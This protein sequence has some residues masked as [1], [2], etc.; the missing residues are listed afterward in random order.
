MNIQLSG[1]IS[2]QRQHQTINTFIKMEQSRLLEMDESDFQR[3]IAEVEIS[4][5]FKRLCYEEKII[6]FH[7]FPKTDISPS[8][9]QLKDN[10]VADEGSLDIKSLV[11]DNEMVV[12]LVQKL[13]IER[14]K[15]YFLFNQTDFSEQDIALECQLDLTQVRAINHLLDEFSTRSEFYHPSAFGNETTRY[16]RIASIERNKE[17]F[18]IGY[19]SPSYAKGKYQIDHERLAVLISKGIISEKD[20][21]EAKQLVK[22]L[23]L[24]NSRKDTVTNILLGIMEKQNLYFQSGDIKSLLT[25]SQKELAA[26]IGVVPSSV[27]RAIYAK[28]IDLPWGEEKPL[29]E[30]FPRP[31]MFKKLIL[32][33]ILDQE[34][35]PRSDEQIRKQL[36]KDYGISVSRRSVARFRKDLNIQASRIRGKKTILTLTE[37]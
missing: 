5:L 27:S 1:Q 28:S 2:T 16:K 19:Y 23:E 6:T 31:S 34:E 37:D 4:P 32:K 9:Y 33:Q 26:N 8:F 12:S 14:F 21:L 35:E 30:F 20:A 25:F 24:I 36:E 29:K 18:I 17:G 15:Q 22:K 11:H 7:R 13:G 3:H 10:I